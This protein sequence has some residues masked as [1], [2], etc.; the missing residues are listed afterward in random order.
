VVCVKTPEVYVDKVF[1]ISAQT[2]KGDIDLCHLTTVPVWSERVSKPLVLP[3]HMVVPPVT[4]PPTV[5]GY[6]VTVK[7]G[8][9]GVGTHPAVAVK[10][11]VAIPLYVP[12]GVHVG[13]KA[14]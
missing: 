10:V 8:E 3:E 1:V 2:L 7:D 9:G 4:L 12:G 5:V 14:F 13:L 11:N 6:T